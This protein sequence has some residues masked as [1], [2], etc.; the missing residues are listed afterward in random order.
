ML[1]TD[2]L[3]SEPLYIQTLYSEYTK[4]IN[5]YS[6]IKRPSQFGRY[7]NINKNASV[8]DTKIKSS[9]DH[10]TTN[11]IVYDLYDYTPLFYTSPVI[12]DSVDAPDLIGK[13]FQGSLTLTTYTI[14]RPVIN[15]LIVFPYL[16]TKGDEIFRVS[17]IRA[18]ISAMNHNIDESKNTWFELTLE[19]APIEDISTI[20]TN[21]KYVYLLTEEKNI[22]MRD[23]KT[24]LQ[25]LSKL[26]QLMIELKTFFNERYEMFSCN[27]A[28]PIAENQKLF[29]YLTKNTENYKR[30]FDTMKVPYGANKYNST[31]ILDVNTMQPI[32][33]FIPPPI[34]NVPILDYSFPIDIYNMNNL[35]LQFKTFVDNLY[36]V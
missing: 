8:I 2:N 25:Q 27:D 13:M 26:Q 3:L 20:K 11:G 1:F 22:F 12:N 19:Y 7:Y 24:L 6:N 32:D 35:L 23:Y 31:D 14:K 21:H 4:L 9:Y 10:F 29:E 33:V 28:Y 15:D 17:N 36:A 30:Y 16:P 5:K 18:V 34:Y